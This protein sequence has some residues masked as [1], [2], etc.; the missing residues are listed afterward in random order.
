MKSM[1]S[2]IKEKFIHQILHEFLEYC[3]SNPEVDLYP[4]YFC[5]KEDKIIMDFLNHRQKEME[6]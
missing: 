3:Y 5:G 2:L 1:L 6:D 4:N